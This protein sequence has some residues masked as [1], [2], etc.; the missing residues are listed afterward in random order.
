MDER[1]CA[2]GVGAQTRV[3]RR[4]RWAQTSVDVGARKRVEI[5]EGLG[6]H[7]QA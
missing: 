7:D 2:D 3:G 1:T 5:E 6:R 4:T